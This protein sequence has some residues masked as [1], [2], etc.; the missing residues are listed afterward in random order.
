MREMEIKVPSG[1]MPEVAE[2][3]EEHELENSIVGAEDELIVV[4]VS[5]AEKKRSVI[6]E[7]LELI[8]DYRDENPDDEDEDDEDDI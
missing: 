3:I 2:L 1:L 8:E 5:Y 6:M 7:L 4:S